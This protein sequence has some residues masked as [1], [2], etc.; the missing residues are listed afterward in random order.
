MCGEKRMT[1]RSTG[2]F[3][4]TLALLFSGCLINGCSDGGTGNTG[5]TLSS[6]GQDPDPV[7]QD[8]P[9]VF[10]MRPFVLNEDGD[11]VMS[12][13]RQL[14]IFEPGAALFIKDRA[15]P[16]ATPRNISD[17]AFV[18]TD[19]N[20]V[21]PPL[22]DV[23]DLSTS[24]DGNKVLFA[25]RGPFD[26]DADLEDQ[27]S[28]NI[29]EYNIEQA[30]LRRIIASDTIAEAGQDREP[31]YLADGRIVFT[32]DR[33]RQA[34]AILLDE[35]RPQFSA[36]D[37]DNREQAFLLHVM[38][39]N[40][41]NIE[42][43]TF[44]QSH[45]REPTV[46]EDGRLIFN[47]WDNIPGRDVVSL[48][49]SQIDGRQMERLYGYHSQDTG[50]DGSTIVFSDPKP[51]E[52]GRL[53]VVARDNADSRPGGDL[54]II[55]TENF[56][57]IDQPSFANTG[58][59][60]AQTSPLADI[61]ELADISSRGRFTAVWPL[62]DGTDRLLIAWSQC[63]LVEMNSDGDEVIVPCTDERLND[64]DNA[65]VEATP[66]YG[67]W[68]LDTTSDLQQPV[69]PPT[70]GNMISEA[71]VLSPRPL[72]FFQSP[73]IDDDTQ[74]LINENAG[75]LHIRSI[76]DFA[77]EDTAVPDLAS[78][79]NPVTTPADQRE[80]LFLRLVKPVSIP[81]DELVDL[82][83]TAFGRSRGELMREI[84]GYAPIH[85]D[86]SV[87]V[88]VPADVP[89]AISLLDADG[90]RVS[91]RHRNWLQVRPGEVLQCNGC[92]SDE[93]EVPHGRLD[94]EAPSI[95]TGGPFAGL[96]PTFLVDP[97]FTM[98]NAFALAN[99]APDPAVDLVFEDI[100]TDP[101]QRTPDPEYRLQYQDLSTPA[102]INSACSP[103]WFANCRITIHFETH[104]HPIWQ[105]D[106]RRFDIDGITLLEDRTCISCHSNLDAM[107]MAQVPAA[108][109]DLT[110][111]ASDIEP[112]HFK[113]YRELLFNDNEQ[114]LVDG[115][116]IDRLEPL[117]DGNGN[118]VFETDED[119]EL[120]LDADN[121]PIPVLRTFN[122]SPSMSTA[123]A[124]ASAEFFTPFAAG[125]S[126]ADYLTPA[127]LKLISEWLDIGAQYYNDPF[128][129][130]Q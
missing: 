75:L 19:A 6:N 103:D 38:D 129:V 22:Y 28:W 61:V 55:D 106:R 52:D 30:A 119:G 29:W 121:N 58:V 8:V 4:L 37:E 97:G 15:L 89:F 48:Y 84:L 65:P 60:E 3:I 31:Q 46:M 102:P 5:L 72:P 70:E 112:D 32:S 12:S 114:E 24:Y 108:Q 116:L 105:V 74:A 23:R 101:D 26:P 113:S 21:D 53:L 11:T 54:I 76:Y 49:R 66:L 124:N 47:R 18:D 2:N 122:I 34:R 36:M 100:W 104:I 120:I 33:Q 16:S 98:A 20:E 127:E 67:L 107:G 7:V 64:P 39:D 83:N 81:S 27:P 79:S 71:V 41:S 96:N 117:L 111:G 115:V 91:P 109:L 43:I 9:V 77:G 59:T 85:P 17:A 87:M 95:N 10:V 56:V 44:N 90:R 35:G 62:Y 63:R 80:A 94:A 1:H 82:P 88:K 110:N 78:V 130:P 45:D 126:H 86:G 92:H 14:N 123:G 51:L 69:Q 42:Q 57:E 93:S 128:V 68:I 125:G 99:G 25:M 13:Q 50:R 118:P 40:G 73:M